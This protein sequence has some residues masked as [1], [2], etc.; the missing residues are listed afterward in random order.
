MLCEKCQEN[1]ACVHLTDIVN[2]TKREYRLCK[3]C[4]EVH[5]V[6]IQAQ[7]QK[8][9]NIT[10]ITL[11]EFCAPSIDIGSG[12]SEVTD[13]EDCPRC[14]MSYS[15]FR[16]EGKFGCSHDYTVFRGSLDDL[17]EKI[18]ASTQ[19]RGRTPGRFREQ[20]NHQTKLDQLREELLQAVQGE[21]YEKAAAIRDQMRL[22][23]SK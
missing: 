3:E 23:G 14:K 21:Q 20:D 2:N 6:S 12:D 4:A 1:E 22:M 9:K 13:V 7:L 16:K 17:L 10:N 15:L 5:G 18:H 19:H 11:P 8:F